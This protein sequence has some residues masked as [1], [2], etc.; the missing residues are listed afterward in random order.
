MQISV[1]KKISINNKKRP[2]IVA[3][4]SGNH[5]GSKKSFLD[6][7]RAAKKAG[8]DLVKI[9]TYEPEDITIKTYDRKFKINKGIW[10]GKYLWDLYK[11]AHTPFE[12]HKSAFALAKKINIPVF[13]SPFSLRS[14]N[15]LSKF[16]PPIYKIAS[17]EITDLN[18][19]KCIA[20]KRK[21]IILS[22]GMASFFEIDNAIKIISKFHKKIILLY[23]VSGYPT[24]EKES[25]VN[26]LKLYQ[27]KYKNLI[28]GISDHTNDINSSLASVALGAKIIEKHFKISN[29]IKSMDSSFSINFSQLKELREKSEKIFL[30]L[31]VE[32]KR[33]KNSEKKSKILRRSIYANANIN[34]GSKLT[35]INITTK[36]PFIGIGSENF[37]KILNKKLKKNKKKFDPIYFKDL[38]FK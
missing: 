30:S 24:P 37:F 15:F 2:L 35:S 16:N 14:L 3:E 9:Q 36:R 29:K 21:P 27:R 12:W 8:A 38:N 20:K 23:C 10:K 1:T 32:E 17:F 26:T 6:H 19:I 4:I 5:N 25:N 22:T 13:S 34:A 18:L 31:G 28:V 33:I 11:I 7:I